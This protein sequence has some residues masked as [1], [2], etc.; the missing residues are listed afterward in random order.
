VTS[1]LVTTG[2]GAAGPRRWGKPPALPDAEPFVAAWNAAEG[3]DA[4]AAAVGM[5]RQDTQRA[6]TALRRLGH[7]LKRMPAVWPRQGSKAAEILW[8]ARTGAAEG[9][10]AIRVGAELEFV[11]R[12]TARAAA[13][14]HATSGPRPSR[15]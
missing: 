4:L 10:I 12:V 3:L 7:A 2:G 6:A 1:E 15:R 9:D 13:A 11:R 5:T 8:L 14:K